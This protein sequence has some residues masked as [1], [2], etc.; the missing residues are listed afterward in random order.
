MGWGNWFIPHSN[1]PLHSERLS[2]I[3]PSSFTHMQT[4][5]GPTTVA[6]ATTTTATTSTAAAITATTSTAAA[7][8]ITIATITTTL[9][10]QTRVSGCVTTFVGKPPLLC[11]RQELPAD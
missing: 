10:C 7:T 11:T 1:Q 3:T 6:A 4:T 8:T 5:I 2:R 9:A